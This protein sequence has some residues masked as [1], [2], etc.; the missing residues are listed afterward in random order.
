MTRFR[1]SVIPIAVTAA[2]LALAPACDDSNSYG[3]YYSSGTNA[4]PRIRTVAQETTTATQPLHAV[5]AFDIGSLVVDDKGFALY[6][7]DRDSADPPTSRCTG[8]CAE[9]WQPV[10][11]TEAEQADGIEAR[12]LGTMTRTDGSDQLT[13]DGW[14]L[15]RYTRDEMPGETAGQGV[16]NAWWP[17]TPDGGR[18]RTSGVITHAGDDQPISGTDRE[19]LSKVRL[20]G[21]WEMPSAMMAREKGQSTRVREIAMPILVDHGRL[22]AATMDLASR[23]GA[24][25]PTEPSVLQQQWL[26]E[27][28]SASGTEFDRVFAN[29]LR[30]AHGKVLTYIANVRAG[31]RNETIRAFATAGNK[32]VMGHITMLESTGMVD[33]ET[34]PAPVLDASATSAGAALDIE[35]TDVFL[36]VVLAAFVGGATVLLLWLIRGRRRDPSGKESKNGTGTVGIDLDELL[37]ARTETG[38]SSHA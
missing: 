37:A 12:L 15:Y 25:M 6:R 24:E 30:L 17:I 10:L 27:Q 4:N 36:I 20:A 11:A 26:D 33:Y 3:S 9:T 2:V 13:L 38:D 1:R 8:D 35:A 22:D 32:A 14:P 28:R 5:K 29:R 31:S 21:L 16:D 18:N 23:F 34:L 7:Y 19:L